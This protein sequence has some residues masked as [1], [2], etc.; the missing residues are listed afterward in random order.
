MKKASVLNDRTTCFSQRYSFFAGGK[1]DGVAPVF[2]EGV[3][4][5]VQLDA[6]LRRSVGQLIYPLLDLFQYI[7]FFIH[8]TSTE[9]ITHINVSIRVISPVFWGVTHMNERIMHVRA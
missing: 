4:L 1:P 9:S 6:D 7:S 5:A 3:G 2:C 8:D